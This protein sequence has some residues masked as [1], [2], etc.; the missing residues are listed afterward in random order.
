M[1]VVLV[2]ARHW[3]GSTIKWGK[4]LLPIVRNSERL[5]G[6]EIFKFRGSQHHTSSPSGH[7]GVNCARM[8]GWTLGA[9]TLQSRLGELR[10]GPK[11]HTPLLT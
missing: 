1:V 4:S 6:A 2:G 10:K 5:A 9:H 8:G 3:Q 11:G 7:F